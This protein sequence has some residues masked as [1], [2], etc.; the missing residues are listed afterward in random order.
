MRLMLT[1]HQSDSSLLDILSSW[2]LQFITS[3]FHFSSN[4][5]HCFNN[6]FLDAS[7]DIKANC[8][9]AKSWQTL[10]R[11]P[12]TVDINVKGGLV[13]SIVFHDSDTN[14][15]KFVV[16][17]PKIVH[18]EDRSPIQFVTVKW[19]NNINRAWNMT[20]HPQKSWVT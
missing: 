17:V 12:V 8:E 6:D 16:F 7:N 3:I 1:S 10:C 5:D 2:S 14:Y 18:C 15:R 4:N 20:K 19:Q 9:R 11:K 13:C